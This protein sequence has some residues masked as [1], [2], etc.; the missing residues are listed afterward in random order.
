MKYRKYSVSHVLK[1]KGQLVV[2][3]TLDQT[4]WKIVGVIPK[5]IH[6]PVRG[7][8][9]GAHD[10]APGAGRSHIHDTVQI[11]ADSVTRPLFTLV[12]AM[13]QFCASNLETSVET[14]RGD[15]IGVLYDS[16]NHMTGE[17]RNLI[18][19]IYQEQEKLRREELKALQAPD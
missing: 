17:M 3:Q 2:Y 14:E 15:E 8:Y 6:Y 5:G 19:T 12:K 11:V 7:V 18:D 9:Q 10:Y 1:D 16:F 13:E 4:D